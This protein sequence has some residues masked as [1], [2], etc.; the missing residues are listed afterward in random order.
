MTTVEKIFYWTPRILSIGFVIF[1]SIFALDAFSGPFEPMMLVYFFLHLMPSF[2]LLGAILIAWKY[3]LVGVVM[4][5]GFAVFYVWSVG[6]ER[7]W[8]WYVAIALPSVIVGILYFIS[9]LFKR[10]RA[11]PFPVK[12]DST[13]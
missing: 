2:I 8:S 7:P 3:D 11:R 10:S 13:K 4:F 12:P 1:L 5:F 6:L 9:W